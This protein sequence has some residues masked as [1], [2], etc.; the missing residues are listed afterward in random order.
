[1]RPRPRPCCSRVC[2]WC[3]SRV[4]TR[5]GTS[6]ACAHLLQQLDRRGLEEPRS[7][8][9]GSRCGSAGSVSKLAVSY[10]HSK[11]GT[12]VVYDAYTH[13]LRVCLV[14]SPDES[15]QVWWYDQNHG[16]KIFCSK[17][18][19]YLNWSKLKFGYSMLWPI[20]YRGES[21]QNFSHRFY[22]P[23]FAPKSCQNL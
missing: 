13:G 19:K 7:G 6:G 20:W 10:V 12:R 2:G 14:R 15:Y 22:H 11:V 18:N 9:L 3:C 16:T 21:Y 23:C 4:V 5:E 1:M 8:V 17:S